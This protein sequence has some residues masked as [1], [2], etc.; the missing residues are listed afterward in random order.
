MTLSELIFGSPIKDK[1]FKIKLDQEEFAPRD[2]YSYQRE[3]RLST[4]KKCIL[5]YKDGTF[6]IISSEQVAIALEGDIIDLKKI[7]IKTQGN[8]DVNANINSDNIYVS[9]DKFYQHPDKNIHTNKGFAKN[10]IDANNITLEGGMTGHNVKLK[11]KEHLKLKSNLS[12]DGLELCAKY[13]FAKANTTIDGISA[14]SIQAHQV[15]SFGKFTSVHTE[16]CAKHVLGLFRSGF[17]GLQSLKINALSYTIAFGATMRAPNVILECG[18]YCNLFSIVRSYDF[19][20][21]NFINLD[22]GLTVPDIPY[23]FKDITN[24]KKI[25]AVVRLIIKSIYAPLGAVLQL[26]FKIHGMFEKGSKANKRFNTDFDLKEDEL[27][28][29][30]TLNILNMFLDLKALFF[31]GKA[32]TSVKGDVI[33]YFGYLAGMKE[34]KD[35]NQIN[36]PNVEHLT[37]ASTA[38]LPAYVSDSLISV[39]RCYTLATTMVGEQH[40]ESDNYV[41]YPPRL[42]Q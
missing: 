20:T 13:I 30:P 22:M 17:Y 19:Y 2:F 24:I 11:A 39:K 12:V 34:H 18:I 15:R 23:E 9:C 28:I 29:K 10:I 5:Q 35:K 8:V 14:L 37:L 1:A 21:N 42:H 31:A 33:D 38:F 27:R 40:I 16:V 7:S 32:I 3:I 26:L 4:G 6:I 25:F 36:Q 41:T